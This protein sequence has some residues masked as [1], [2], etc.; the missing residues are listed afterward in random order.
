MVYEQDLDPFVGEDE[1][2]EGEEKP[3]ETEEKASDD[4]GEEGIE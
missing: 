4:E 2:E 3:E 1:S